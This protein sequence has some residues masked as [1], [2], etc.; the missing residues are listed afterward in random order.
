MSKQ[1]VFA[2]FDIG[3]TNKKLLL[4]DEHYRLLQEESARFEETRDEDGFPAE[5]LTRLEDWIQEGFRRLLLHKK[6]LVEALNI[7]AYGASFVHVSGSGMPLTP[8]YNY[9]KPYPQKWRDRFYEQ[10]GG[11]ELVSRETASPALG[12]LN[13]GLQMYRLKYEQPDIFNRIQYSLHLPQYLSFYLSGRP[14]AELT[15]I[16]CH[17]LLWDFNQHR[18]HDWVIAEGLEKKFPAILPPDTMQTIASGGQKIKVGIG[19]HDSSAALIPYLKSFSEPFV[20]ISTGTWSISLNP[21]NDSPLTGEDLRHDCLCY[22]TPGGRPVKAA[23]LFAGREHEEQTK[24]LA[25]HF[26]VQ[27]NKYNSIRF[28]PMLFDRL[29]HNTEN[30][31]PGKEGNGLRSSAFAGRSLDEFSTYQEAYH[32]LM[33]DIVA[34][35]FCSTSRVLSGTRVRKIFVDGGFGKNE[36]YMNMLA[37]YFPDLQIYAADVAQASALGAALLLNGS[38]VEKKQGLDGSLVTCKAFRA[39]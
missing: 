22:L 21:F 16:G 34:Q 5:N 6:Y 8:L 4:F 20:L 9:L 12:S 29:Q 1:K 27:E 33:F 25:A 3:K 13:S 11:E 30:S 10:Y 2:V 36:L 26:S 7:S 23:R 37:R 38:G 35:Q 31:S 17:T 28:D 24:R 18:Y 39:E 14:A 32:Q 15:S 19:L